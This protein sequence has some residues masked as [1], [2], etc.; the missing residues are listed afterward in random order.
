MT[1]KRKKT[2]HKMRRTSKKR[3]SAPIVGRGLMLFFRKRFNQKFS[4]HVLK[5]ADALTYEYI[6]I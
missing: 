3:I 5:R 4:K 1:D 2:T 6:Y